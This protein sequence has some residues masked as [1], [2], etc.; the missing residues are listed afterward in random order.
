V[1]L[2]ATHRQV[3]SSRYLRPGGPWDV[4]SLDQL[5]A[6]HPVAHG[7]AVVDSA[8][9][10]DAAPLSDS[11]AALAGGLRSAG[12]VTGDA[13]AWQLP[14]CIE[15]LLLYRACWRIGAIAVPLHH[16]TGPSELSRMVDV[17]EPKVVFSR[18]GLPLHDRP[19]V[20]TAQGGDDGW[21]T[22]LAAKPV[23][24]GPARGSQ[25]AVALFTS[26]STGEPKAVLH[27]HRALSYRP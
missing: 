11:V 26:G 25:L 3:A 5:A 13:V 22:M 27:T 20:L 7:A 4:P 15:A 9:R 16:Q 21:E 17:V 10:L 8:S 2:R 18:T 23:H 12:V 6:D 14:N 1:R 19:G 24:R